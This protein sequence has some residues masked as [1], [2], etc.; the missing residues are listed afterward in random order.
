MY[1]GKEFRVLGY[2]SF[3]SVK[4][5]VGIINLYRLKRWWVLLVGGYEVWVWFFG[6][7][8]KRYGR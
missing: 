8:V 2:R 6:S 4:C 3:G 1:F 7:L 5:F